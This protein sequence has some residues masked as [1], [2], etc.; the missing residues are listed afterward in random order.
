LERAVTEV[1]STEWL[2]AALGGR[3]M[4]PVL[5]LHG[6][7]GDR[8]YGQYWPGLSWQFDAPV[9]DRGA[10]ILSLSNFVQSTDPLGN[11]TVGSWAQTE[12]PHAT[13]E[14]D[15]ADLQMSAMVGLEYLL[16]KDVEIYMTFNGLSPDD[17]VRKISGQVRQWI[18]TKRSLKLEIQRL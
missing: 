7:L 6:G 9:I 5:V 4:V 12:L 18:L 14:L 16:G 1:I 3:S 17:A 2:T 13:V 8:I 10:R 15:N 11:A